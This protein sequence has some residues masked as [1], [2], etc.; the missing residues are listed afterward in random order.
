ME[1]IIC[2]EEAIEEMEREIQG[3]GAIEDS[4]DHGNVNDRATRDASDDDADTLFRKD[5]S[6]VKVRC[7][8]EVWKLPKV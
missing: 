5:M 7:D 3:D 1:R 2:E 4:V 6:S 8:S